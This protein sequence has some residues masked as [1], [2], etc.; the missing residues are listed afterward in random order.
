MSADLF[1]EEAILARVP[2]GYGKAILA[3]PVGYQ[4]AAIFSFLI[5][6]TLV[7]FL[8]YGEYT[9]KE[10]VIGHVKATSGD[11]KIYPT[12]AGS[13]TAVHV[14][15]G[16]SIAK[17]QILVSI[18]TGRATASSNNVESEILRALEQQR[19]LAEQRIRTHHELYLSKSAGYAKN[20][21]S[22]DLQLGSLRAQRAKAIDTRELAENEYQRIALLEK[23]R[24]IAKA[25]LERAELRTLEADLRIEDFNHQISLAQASL[26]QFE[27][28]RSQVSIQEDLEANE[29]R[30]NLRSLEQQIIS[31]RSHKELV[32]RA[33]V[34]GKV[35]ALDARPGQAVSPAV[36]I[37]SIVATD[38]EFYV[39]LFAPARVIGF[40]RE[41]ANVN[42]RYDSFPYQKFGLQ[43][44]EVMQI[45]QTITLPNELNAPVAVREPVYRVRV[46]LKEQTVAGYG[47]I[48]ELQPGMSL[49]ADVS[50]DRRRIIAWIFEPL[51]SATTRMQS[52]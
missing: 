32:I 46:R 22:H 15:E 30:S 50:R 47:R 26:D 12:Q 11:V 14:A 38:S 13:I 20:I 45:S 36:P 2:S 4:A 5:A 49:A 37:A 41:G 10:S 39:E 43:Q 34:A 1:R 35:T 17:G 33:T 44:G 21:A 9:R 3:T 51:I 6:V 42:I 24:L 52:P 48:F 28:E 8:C 18:G 27:F 7:C 16:D 40:I 31:T 25:D 29:I 23:K 19:I